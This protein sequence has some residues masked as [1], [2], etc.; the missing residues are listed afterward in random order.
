MFI[1]ELLVGT[2]TFYVYVYFMLILT[3]SFVLKKIPVATFCGSCSY[4]EVL[5]DLKKLFL[6]IFYQF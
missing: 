4:N 1:R 2:R 5:L 3:E 6:D